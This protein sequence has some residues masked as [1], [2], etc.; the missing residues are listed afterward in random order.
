MTTACSALL[1]FGFAPTNGLSPNRQTEDG[2]AAEAPAVRAT[3]TSTRSAIKD[4]AGSLDERSLRNSSVGTVRLRAKAMQGGQRSRRRDLEESA[5]ACGKA[6]SVVVRA[7]ECG[8]VEISVASLNHL[9]RTCP[10]RAVCQSA[11]AVKRN[12][13]A[14]H[15]FVEKPGSVCPTREDCSVDGP[16][17]RLNRRSRFSIAV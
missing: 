5:A 17:G 11:K 2:A 9:I 14:P 3:P 15:H 8:P 10:V 6:N 16:V 1:K 4:P 13:L 7:E 12:Q